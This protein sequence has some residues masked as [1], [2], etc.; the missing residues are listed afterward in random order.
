MPPPAGQ[1]WSESETLWGPWSAVSNYVTSGAAQAGS[2]PAAARTGTAPHAPM[3]MHRL[4]TWTC[5]MPACWAPALWSLRQRCP[6]AA[7]VLCQAAAGGGASGGPG[8][9]SHALWSAAE[10][11]AAASG[12]S[13]GASS[14][15]KK[16][17][18]PAAPRLEV[19]EAELQRQ[20]QEEMLVS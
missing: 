20:A 8:A 7:S 3:A 9:Q 17:K 4:M 5:V 6:A 13:S 11:M 14:R 16:G 10:P 1:K 15:K 12:G 19:D 2:E 18:A